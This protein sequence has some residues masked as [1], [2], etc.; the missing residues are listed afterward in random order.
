MLSKDHA[1]LA[2]LRPWGSCSGRVP[3]GNCGTGA[4]G[5]VAQAHRDAFVRTFTVETN[6]LP[7]RGKMGK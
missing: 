7:L 1:F 2:S 3:S 5:T 4:Q 6:G